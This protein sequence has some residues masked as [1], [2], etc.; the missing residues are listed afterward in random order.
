M[1]HS[2]LGDS[3]GHGK[4]SPA[5]TMD[6]NL[7]LPRHIQERKVSHCMPVCWNRAIENRTFHSELLEGLME[8]WGS[9][10]VCCLMWREGGPL[11][12]GCF[13][14][15]NRAHQDYAGAK[16]HG[17]HCW[18]E[19]RASLPDSPRP[20]SGCVVLLGIQR[21]ACRLWSGWR[22]LRE[23]RRGES[24]WWNEL[25]LFI[26]TA[27]VNFYVMQCFDIGEGLF[28]PFCVLSV[29]KEFAE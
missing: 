18:R 13:D 9:C 1:L 23:S 16:Q 29:M 28:P 11:I 19:H 6:W 4:L 25:Y 20:V 14:S 3:V 12:P 22:S 7:K 2:F 10:Q 15:L 8:D 24:H 17:D 27:L 5:M 21:A 26:T